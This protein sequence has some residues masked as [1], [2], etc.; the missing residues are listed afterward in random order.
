MPSA[1]GLRMTAAERI[2][3]AAMTGE[4]Y[5]PEGGAVA[6][7]VAD[8]ASAKPK[9]KLK[10]KPRPRPRPKP[11]P[12]PKLKTTLDTNAEQ[13]EPAQPKRSQKERKRE[14]WEERG[15]RFESGE[16]ERAKE[17]G[18]EKGNN[19]SERDAKNAEEQRKKEIVAEF[20]VERALEARSEAGMAVQ[21]GHERRPGSNHDAGPKAPEPVREFVAE[22]R[23]LIQGILKRAVAR[24]DALEKSGEASGGEDDRIMVATEKLD[25][26]K[27]RL[28]KATAARDVAEAARKASKDA[29]DLAE[30]AKQA[31]GLAQLRRTELFAE[32]LE[33]IGLKHTAAA[34]IA[35][36]KSS[37]DVKTEATSN[38]ENAS[39]S[40]SKEILANHLEAIST[41]E[42]EDIDPVQKSIAEDLPLGVVRA[43]AAARSA[44]ARCARALGSARGAAAG[45]EQDFWSAVARP[46]CDIRLLE[47]DADDAVTMLA[48]AA[49]AMLEELRAADAEVRSARAGALKSRSELKIIVTNSKTVDKDAKISYARARR[50]KA[51]LAMQNADEA[52]KASN[53]ALKALCEEFEL[54]DSEDDEGDNDDDMEKEDGRTEMINVQNDV[55]EVTIKTEDQSHGQASRVAGDEKNSEGDNTDYKKMKVQKKSDKETDSKDGGDKNVDKST[56]NTKSPP[57]KQRAKAQ[58]LDITPSQ[59]NDSNRITQDQRLEKS[60]EDRNEE[61]NANNDEMDVD[62]DDMEPGPS[63]SSDFED[64]Q[65]VDKNAK[66]NKKIKTKNLSKGGTTKTLHKGKLPKSKDAKFPSD[67][68]AEDEDEDPKGGREKDNNKGNSGAM[69]E[70]EASFTAEEQGENGSGDLA[71]MP[72]RNRYD[73]DDDDGSSSSDSDIVKGASDDADGLF[74][75]PKLTK[76]AFLASRGIDFNGMMVENND[77]EEDDLDPDKITKS[78]ESTSTR[79]NDKPE[80]DDKKQEKTDPGEHDGEGSLSSASTSGDIFSNATKKRKTSGDL[81]QP[82]V[83]STSGAKRAKSGSVSNEKTETAKRS[84]SS[85]SP[86]TSQSVGVSIKTEPGTDIHTKVRNDK[87]VSPEQQA[88]LLQ[89]HL[90]KNSGVNVSGSSPMLHVYDRDYKGP[91]VGK[92]PGLERLVGVRIRIK[93]SSTNE[94]DCEVIALRKKE[95]WCFTACCSSTLPGGASRHVRLRLDEKGKVYRHAKLDPYVSRTIQDD[96]K[97]HVVGKAK[98]IPESDVITDL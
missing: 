89:R 67:M 40:E 64:M 29:A 48:V 43:D 57:V 78:N 79:Q 76:R 14:R 22:A 19:E 51:R 98:P 77:E 50:A 55:G 82:L 84:A 36:L 37:N 17:S 49:P 47:G 5:G 68:E 53:A 91:L 83:H 15:R 6:E 92:F 97:Y 60:T 26:A 58:S 59:K 65:E 71:F 32:R 88:V 18:G 87:G 34:A 23:A 8:R 39:K 25:R 52:L 69:E 72:I 80:H 7:G 3:L 95:P 12:K 10:P 24:R 2:A 90:A 93:W 45:L 35:H 73:D 63:T 46:H 61:E 54:N 1:Q 9:P 86:P 62:E 85:S 33:A 70:D 96:S 28:A 31:R 94:E 30:A 38:S 20:S 21:G 11:K 74:K 44:R 75:Q 13:L 27:A 81:N 41:V 16:E 42:A 4:A 66:E 56:D